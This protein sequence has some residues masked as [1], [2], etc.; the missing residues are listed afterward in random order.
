MGNT[1]KYTPFQ[2]DAFKE[3]DETSAAK[4]NKGDAENAVANYGD[5]KESAD[6]LLAKDN[7]TN[8]ENALAN[9]GDFTYSKQD[10]FADIMDKILNREKFSYDLNG[11][12]LYQQYKDKYI[13]QG[14][15]AMGDAIGQASAMTGGYGNSYA[16]S[17]GQQQY[18]AQ[19][20]N[21]NDIVPE[22]YQMALDKHNMEGQDLYNQYGMLS[23]D[24]NMEY[25]M[26][27]D[28]R[29]ALVADRGYY[30]SEYDNAF[31]R[32]YGMWAD[33]RDAL[34]ADRGYYA[35][36]YDNAFNRDYGM[37]S[38]NRNL[39]HSEHT[40]S[41]ASKYQTI[42]DAVA[43]EQW[44][45]DYDFTQAKWEYEKQQLER[46]AAAAEDASKSYSGTT[47]KGWYNNNGLTNAQVKEIQTMLG[48]TADG[49]W[50]EE[51]K[52]AADGLTAENAYKKFILGSTEF[53]EKPNEKPGDKPPSY[54]S[55]V[56]DLNDLI[57]SGASKSEIN[58]A[59][60]DALQRGWI[61]QGQ[62]ST[63][64]D[65]YAPRGYAY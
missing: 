61:T 30:A 18:Q 44:Q 19:L 65:Q 59:L 2:Y 55:I 51:S 58:S 50:G 3:S 54:D 35:S 41:E 57:A 47:E 13:K 5:F 48:V 9:Y 39:A 4:K 11:D 38:D 12:A 32:D 8:A 40:T 14:K 60:R 25:G 15:L 26:W 7:K 37:Y 34:V 64:K 17:V 29:N 56:T 63:L 22:L 28:K 20:E 45:K 24:R 33:N 62:Y 52:R 49:Y 21:L 46:E 27:G 16:Q 43:D 1:Y 36:E 31:N 42:R 53:D 6:T 23:D 10:P